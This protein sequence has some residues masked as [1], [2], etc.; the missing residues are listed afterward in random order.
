[1]EYLMMGFKENIQNVLISEFF[2]DFFYVYCCN[3]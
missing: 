1:M 3:A 2:M